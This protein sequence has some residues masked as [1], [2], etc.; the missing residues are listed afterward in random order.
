MALLTQL[1]GVYGTFIVPHLHRTLAL[2]QSEGKT[3]HW[4]D[5]Y[6]SGPSVS[7]LAF[8]VSVRHYRTSAGQTFTHLGQV[9]PN[10]HQCNICIIALALL[11][12]PPSGSSTS[13]GFY[14]EPPRW[15]A[16]SIYSGATGATGSPQWVAVSVFF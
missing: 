2:Y 6:P 16:A 8:E 3:L 13:K 4:A 11:L 1:L 10:L 14:S 5:F 15:V 9:S 12:A 7:E